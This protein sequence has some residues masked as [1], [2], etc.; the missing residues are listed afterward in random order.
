MGGGRRNLQPRGTTDVEEGRQGYRRDGQDLI[1][2]WQDQKQAR[3]QPAAYVW[4][5]RDLLSLNLT[6]I[7]YLLGRPSSLP[8]I[9]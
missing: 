7:D 9:S 3:G 8:C 4:N 2:A 1:Q 6:D 5:R